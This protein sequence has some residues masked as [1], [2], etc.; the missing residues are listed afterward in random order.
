[1]EDTTARVTYHDETTD[2]TIVETSTGHRIQYG[3]P[4]GDS[5]CYSHSCFECIDTLTPAER[6]AIRDAR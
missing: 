4:A 1:M 3:G 5:F 6:A 2:T